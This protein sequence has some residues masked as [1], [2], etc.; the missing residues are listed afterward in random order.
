MN[1]VPHGAVGSVTLPGTGHRHAAGGIGT[2]IISFWKLPA[3]PASHVDD[4]V[5]LGFE[6][7]INTG[8]GRFDRAVKGDRLAIDTGEICLAFYTV[9][10]KSATQTITWTL[11]HIRWDISTFCCPGN[12]CEST[13]WARILY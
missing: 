11:H 3:K 13:C 5:L 12:Y 4:E 2:L 10:R 6:V 7:L 8:D 9:C 1:V